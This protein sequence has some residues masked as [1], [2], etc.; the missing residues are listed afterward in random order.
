MSHK[1]EETAINI[2]YINYLNIE[3][4]I[5]THLGLV[6]AMPWITKESQ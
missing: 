1:L 2:L 5:V 4:H 3:F 6:H